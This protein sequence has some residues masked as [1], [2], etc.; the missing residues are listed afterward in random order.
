MPVL[1]LK[2]RPLSPSSALWTPAFIPKAAGGVSGSEAG[3]VLG[4]AAGSQSSGAPRAS[5]D[6]SDGRG[7]RPGVRGDNGGCRGCCD[8]FRWLFPESSSLAALATLADCC[9]AS[10]M[11]VSEIFVELQGFLAQEQDIQE[12][13]RKAV[14][15]LEQAAPEILTLLQGIHQ[16]AGFQDNFMSTGGLY[17]SAW[18][19]WQHLLCIWK[20]KH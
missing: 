20:Q 6:P 5:E 11:S 19:S 13:I 17:C 10:A 2:P 7:V 1:R 8:R 4:S 18:S 9:A 12:E 14:Q 15:S 3:S 16:G